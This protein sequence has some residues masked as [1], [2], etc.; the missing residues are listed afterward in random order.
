ME[1][2]FTTCVL[3]I[4]SR[5]NLNCTYCYMYNKGD[6]S[7][8]NQPKFMSL[9]TIDNLIKRFDEYLKEYKYD[10]FNFVFHGG[11]PML[12]SKSLYRYF[13]INVNKL[14]KK[15][16]KQAKYS[17]QTNGVLINKEWIKFFKKYGIHV[18]ISLDTTK[19]SN[20]INRIYHNGKSSYNDILKG[21]NT[22]NEEMNYK[23]GVYPTDQV[24]V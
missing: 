18:G 19:K 7:F 22:F 14:F 12:A 8:L 21:L 5:C 4:A 11:E 23:A 20:D 17:I 15:Y 3:K 2:Q 10:D 24:R 9:D 16:K 6:L 1:I 13:I